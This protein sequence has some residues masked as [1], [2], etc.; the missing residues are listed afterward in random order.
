MLSRV[1]A[2]AGRRAADCA[3]LRRLGDWAGRPPSDSLRRAERRPRKAEGAGWLAHWMP[4]A[5]E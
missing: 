2:A 4:A 3:R 1:T 5:L